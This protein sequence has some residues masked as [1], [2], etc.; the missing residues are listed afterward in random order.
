[1]EFSRDFLAFLGLF[2]WFSPVFRFG[3]RN[4]GALVSRV[5]PEN[6][7]FAKILDM[8][9][10]KFPTDGLQDSRPPNNDMAESLQSVS[11]CIGKGETTKSTHN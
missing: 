5:L 9:K 2:L 6:L 11:L 4:E 7:C 3:D 8:N 1:M 10:T